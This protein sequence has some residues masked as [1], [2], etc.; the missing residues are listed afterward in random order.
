MSATDPLLRWCV[1]RVPKH[2]HT[3][4]ECEDA[5]AADPTGRRFAV[6]DGA[7]ESAFA[8]LWARLLV[9]GFVAAPRPRQP[10]TWLDG[11]R[12]RWAAEVMPLDLPWYAEMK[13]LEGAYATLL[14]L[15]VRGPTG[16]RPGRWRAV[17]VGDSCL[18]QVHAGE[19]ARSFPVSRS[20]EFGNQPGLIGSR[21]GPGPL[22]VWDAGSLLAG[23]R[24]LLM[25]DA[26]AQWFLRVHEEG[27]RPWDELAAVLS[28]GQPESAFAAWIEDLRRGEEMRNDDVTLLAIESGLAPEE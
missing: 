10:A 12:R 28:P 15:S 14:G 27:R 2:G 6:A 26:L 3:A 17:A 22:P 18:F 9:E 16:D 11:Q 24:L 4:D 23:D 8:G 25:T 20:S 5:W 21:G 19:K 7:S 13:R 1:R